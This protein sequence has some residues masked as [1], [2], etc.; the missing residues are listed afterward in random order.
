LGQHF[1]SRRDFDHALQAVKKRW[2]IPVEEEMMGT[3]FAY[4]DSR[5]DLGHFL[6]YFS[7]PEDSPFTKVPKY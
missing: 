3:A 2:S 1:S 6:E 5:K 4:I 7:F